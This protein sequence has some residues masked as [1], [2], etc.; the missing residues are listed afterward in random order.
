MPANRKAAQETK[1][2]KLWDSLEGKPGRA[3]TIAK[4]VG[5]HPVTIVK[6]AHKNGKEVTYPYNRPARLDY[7]EIFKLR[8]KRNGRGGALFTHRDLAEI[9]ECSKSAIT[10]ILKDER[11][12]Y[13]DKGQEPPAWL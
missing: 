5:A 9:C 7:K 8:K 3:E 12:R 2:M 10:K 6:W 13:L 11:Q 4:K 1:A